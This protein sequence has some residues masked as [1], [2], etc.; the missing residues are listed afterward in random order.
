MYVINSALNISLNDY[1]YATRLNIFLNGPT[2]M[3]NHCS[4]RIYSLHG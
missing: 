1:I 2:E 3:G 4:V